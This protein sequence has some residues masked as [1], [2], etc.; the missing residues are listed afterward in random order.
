[1]NKSTRSRRHSTIN[2]TTRNDTYYISPYEYPPENFIQRESIITILP[3]NKYATYIPGSITETMEKVKA[4]DLEIE[5]FIRYWAAP[6]LGIPF[7]ENIYY[8]KEQLLQVN[9]CLIIEK[10][11][12]YYKVNETYKDYYSQICLLLT[13]LGILTNSLYVRSICKIV[14]KGGKAIQY[15]LKKK[16]AEYE[17]NDIDIIL[18]PL[19]NSNSDVL[20]KLGQNISRFLQWTSTYE[21]SAPFL[22]I[23]QFNDEQPVLHKSIVK[24][25]IQTGDR[26]YLALLDIGIGY[27]ELS[28]FMKWLYSHDKEQSHFYIESINIQGNFI[29]ENIYDLIME[30]I[31]YVIKY[32]S[33]SQIKNIDNIRF[34]RKSH[35]SLSRLLSQ[36]SMQSGTRKVILTDQYIEFVLAYM[37]KYE[38]LKEDDVLDKAS[39]FKT[40]KNTFLP[41]NI[42]EYYVYER[43]YERET[44]REIEKL[45]T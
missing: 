7:I 9:T 26:G 16:L 15:S 8:M 1:M 33:P 43:E 25:S 13:W 22:S 2:R 36:A 18:V 41:V 34:L 42:M 37:Y 31:Y 44:M 40:I 3:E 30:K 10:H 27:H 39:L 35:D 17:S 32:S 6:I 19:G 38:E 5:D 21:N 20:L 14:V 23:L 28:S 11:F 24:I 12:P 45:D 29:Y 4:I